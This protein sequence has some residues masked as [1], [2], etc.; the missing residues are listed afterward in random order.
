MKM[1]LISYLLLCCN[2]I[3]IE[4]SFE[5]KIVEII[6]GDTCVIQVQKQRTNA[7]GIKTKIEKWTEKI[8]IQLYGVSAPKGKQPFADEDNKE[9]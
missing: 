2:L 6:N 8:T 3:A 9:F 1:R 7:D 4:K 5:G